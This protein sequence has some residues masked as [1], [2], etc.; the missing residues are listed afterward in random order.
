MNNKCFNCYF[1]DK[2]K[3]KNLCDGYSSLIDEFTD[4][5]I[6]DIIESGRIEFFDEWQE[7]ITEYDD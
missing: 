4:S 7:Y 6:L 3:D 2:C 5:E 1:G